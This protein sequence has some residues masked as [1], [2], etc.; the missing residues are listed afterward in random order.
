MNKKVLTFSLWGNIPRYL[1][2]AIKN[3]ELAE[4]F[5]PDFECWFYI[6]ESS[7]SKDIVTQ[8]LNKTNTKIIFKNGDLLFNKPMCWRFEAI[9]DPS[10][11]IM[12]PRDTDTRILLREK[13]AVNEWL[14]S[15]KLLHIMRDH[16]IYHNYKIF[17]GMFGTKK[18][19]NIPSWK[20]IINSI[21]QKKQNKM[22][23]LKVLNKI[24]EKI[25]NN[26]ILV[27]TTA[28]IFPNEI[29]RD[30]P[31]LYDENYNFVGCYIYEDESR[32]EEHHK[33]L[34]DK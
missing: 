7:V 1:I 21:N 19:P 6:H 24:L 27:H 32:C 20:Y 22:Y 31:I 25:D 34:K 29:T 3:A 10:V 13:L 2:G 17:G 26:L 30:F 8:L 15:D 12:M 11:E 5:Y 16:K 9:D 18:I 28:K 4:K 14:L 33:I 23:D